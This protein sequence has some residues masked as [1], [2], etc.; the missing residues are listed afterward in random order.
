MDAKTEASKRWPM[1]TGQSS[2]DAFLAG[3]A[4]AL[5]EFGDVL[6]NAAANE[7]SSNVPIA[8][9]EYGWASEAHHIADG[10]EG[11]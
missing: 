11:L 7:S 3:A 5:R 4:W 1:G 8:V 9:A 10:I 6:E 2:Y